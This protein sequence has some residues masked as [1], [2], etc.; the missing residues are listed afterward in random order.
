MAYTSIPVKHDTKERIAELESKDGR[1]WDTFLRRELLGED[2]DGGDF[3]HSAESISLSEK[4]EEIDAIQ[5][6]V[7]LTNGM[8]L[9]DPVADED[10]TIG[11]WLTY[12]VVKSKNALTEDVDYSHVVDFS[13]VPTEYDGHAISGRMMVWVQYYLN[14]RGYFVNYVDFKKEHYVVRSVD[15]I[16]RRVEYGVPEE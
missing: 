14:Q 10:F 7:E 9:Y 16:L 5:E 13:N 1:Q 11:N 6:A 12:E 15:L 3:Y 4:R 8:E 2:I